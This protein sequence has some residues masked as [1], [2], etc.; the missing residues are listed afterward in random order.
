MNFFSLLIGLTLAGVGAALCLWIVRSIAAIILPDT[1]GLTEK[2]RFR[3]RERHAREADALIERQD[4]SGALS[5]LQSSFYLDA[6]NLPEMIE[7]VT[8]LHLGV[9][10]RLLLVSERK[11]VK[12]SNLAVIEDLLL[13]RAEMM[14]SHVDVI[15]SRATLSRRRE[16]KTPAWAFE[17]YQKRLDELNDRLKTNRKSLLS[18]L[19]ILFRTLRQESSREEV[20]YH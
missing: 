13:S 11:G 10:S 3:S 6:I 2:I 4:W 9:L 17:E 5:A 12:L 1:R 20:T 16:R 19:E 8:N 7:R 15:A 14:R 18:Q